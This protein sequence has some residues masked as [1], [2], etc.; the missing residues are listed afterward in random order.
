MAAPFS[1]K[2]HARLGNVL[3]EV[4]S[5]NELR[6]RREALGKLFFVRCQLTFG[7]VTPCTMCPMVSTRSP[8]PAAGVF[9]LNRPSSNVA[10]GRRA[11]EALFTGP[12]RF[13]PTQTDYGRRFLIEG[14]AAVGSVFSTESVPK[15]IRRRRNTARSCT[16]G[17]KQRH[18][19]ERGRTAKAA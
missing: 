7:H 4:A 10:E 17:V 18:G 19:A 11:L 3:L 2:H 13:T 12:L 9:A 6:H 16:F 5:P 8:L 1:A 15:G 14:K